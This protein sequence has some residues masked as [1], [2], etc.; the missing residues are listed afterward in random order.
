MM[1]ARREFGLGWLAKFGARVV[2]PF[3]KM[4]AISRGWEDRLDPSRR[5][6]PIGAVSFR[7]QRAE[8]RF[9]EILGAEAEVRD[10]R[11]AHPRRRRRPHR[12]DPADHPRLRRQ[13]RGR[14]VDF[15]LSSWR[16]S[17]S[18]IAFSWRKAAPSPRNSRDRRPPPKILDANSATGTGDV[19]AV[20][21]STDVPGNLAVPSEGKLENMPIR[22]DDR[23][24]IVTGSGGGLD[25]AMRWD[26][27][28]AARKS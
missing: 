17:T 13:P 5:R 9:C 21:L 26:W 12:G 28:P 20:L 19:D 11:R 6:R 25:A 8:S 10:L 2:A 16:S 22:F 27:R 7:R 4:R 3:S 18:R 14:D 15:V 24:L 23:V 1:P